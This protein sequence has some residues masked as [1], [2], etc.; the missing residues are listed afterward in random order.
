M[1]KRILLIALAIVGLGLIATGLSTFY[2]EK[3]YSGSP[4]RNPVTTVKES[5]GFPLGWYGYSYI[6]EMMPVGHTEM[7]YWFSLESFL[8]DIGFWFAI[9]SLAVIAVTFHKTS[10]FKKLSVINI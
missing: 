5:C 3:D 6:I 10:A 7:V 2:G 1:R 9:S 4:I 8:L